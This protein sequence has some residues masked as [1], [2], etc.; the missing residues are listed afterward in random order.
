MSLFSSSSMEITAL[1]LDG[2]A[3]RHKVLS[4]N[5]AN[6]QTKDFTRS[7]VQF[8]GK[9]KQILSMEDAKEANRISNAGSSFMGSLQ[10]NHNFLQ[11]S[12]SEH[13]NFANFRPSV[14]L[15]KDSPEISNGNN[16]NIET[17]MVELSKNGT[18]YTILSELQGR[19]FR[20][21]NDIVKGANI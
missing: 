4:A 12:S 1:A 9:L 14:V 6:A 17:E 15:D 19:M 20:K 21:M 11:T 18:R 2:L 16:V 5:V 10:V 8:E 13:N 7:D 3:Q